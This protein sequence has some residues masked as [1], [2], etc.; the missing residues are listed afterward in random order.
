MLTTKAVGVGKTADAS[1]Q[2]S[3]GTGKTRPIPIIIAARFFLTADFIARFINI[4][5]QQTRSHFLMTRTNYRLV[6]ALALSLILH[7]APL[8]SELI[9]ALISLPP[10]VRQSP[11]IAAR[12]RPPPPAPTPAPQAP[13]LMP[14]QAPPPPAA[15]LPKVSL[16]KP[17]QPRIIRESPGRTKNWQE[18]VRQQLKKMDERGQFYPAAA[19][20]QGLE[21]EALVLLIIDENG[22]VSAARLEQSSGH[23]LLDDAALRA[24]RSLR[25]LPADAPR[26]SLLPVRFRLK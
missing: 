9:S 24:V 13:L 23:R 2:A 4:L 22:Q 8:A 16:P 26:D 3:V 20:A 14:E 6:L 1:A 5:F 21:G 10:P 17:P 11:P 19:I 18:E 25:S 15:S 12:L 7:F